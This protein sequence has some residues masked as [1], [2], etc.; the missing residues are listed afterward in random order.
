MPEGNPTPGTPD[1]GDGTTASPGAAEPVL[2]VV[3]L[4]TVFHTPAGV[5]RAVNGI[6]YSLA[7][8]EALAIVGESGSGKT[9]GVL[10]LMGLVPDPPGRIENGQVFL[11]GRN[12]LDLSPK[13]WQDV[14]GQEIAMI[15]QDPMTS[16]NPVLTIG[17]QLA[18]GVR[19]HMGLSKRDALARAQEL[20][21][22]VGIPDAGERLSDYPHQFSG[23]QRQR[24]MIAMALSCS[25]SVL[26]ADEPTTALDVTIQAQIVELVQDLRA[27]LGMAIV[28]ITHDLALVAGLVDRVAVMYAGFIVEMADVAALYRQPLHP[29]TLGLMESMPRLDQ[30]VQE[31][32]PSIEGLPPDLRQSFDACPFEPRCAFAIDRCRSERPPLL[33]AGS[34]RQSA[35][36]RWQ[37]VA[38]GAVETGHGEAGP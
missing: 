4:E 35:C 21:E 7:L 34:G 38:E 1:D 11:N 20:M 5:V 16:L 3:D 26:L 18:E 2:R 10:S 28:W 36:W 32:L 13:Q 37:D 15:F 29:Y 25:P 31:H 8:G 30:P 12:V 24:I 17:H 27:K 14:R 6:S 9:V 19:R 23:G 22:L 33:D